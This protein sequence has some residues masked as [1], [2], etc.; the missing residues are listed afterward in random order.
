MT[1]FP[2]SPTRRPHPFWTHRAFRVCVCVCVTLVSF[3][4]TH[5]LRKKTV[6]GK[7]PMIERR[8]FLNPS[9]IHAPYDNLITTR[10]AT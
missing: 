2:C 4:L 6:I 5:E 3:M 9:S 8:N 7:T 10:T 1:T